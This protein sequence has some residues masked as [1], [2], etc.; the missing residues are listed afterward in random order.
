[1]RFRYH[2]QVL[3][4]IL[5]ILVIRDCSAKEDSIFGLAKGI[6]GGLNEADTRITMDALFVR[7]V[8]YDLKFDVIIMT[9]E[10]IESGISE[11][12]IGA[13][14]VS[15]TSYLKYKDAGLPLLPVAMNVANGNGTP[16]VQYVLLC[17]KQKQP[18]TIEDFR[19]K[20]LITTGHTNSLLVDDLWLDL[21]LNEND[22]PRND[23]FFGGKQHFV[24]P[25]KVL[26]PLFFGKYD[27][28]LVK[29]AVWQVMA[30]LKPQIG[31]QLQLLAESPPLIELMTCVN[32]DVLPKYRQVQMRNSM[33]N[34]DQSAEGR[35]LLRIIK[36]VRFIDFQESF[37]SQNR[38]LLN[39]HAAIFNNRPDSLPEN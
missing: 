19:G 21:F 32:T 29:K 33:V 26:I 23:Q 16:M 1:M 17:K 7:T 3:L 4:L 5:G 20:S 31:T 36:T 38:R 28:C 9:D 39:E 37:L 2:N 10:Q 24:D 8:K 25:H 13:C 35:N 34:M 12:G 14:T 6:I 15:A 30:E 11:G 27:I 22:L 18:R